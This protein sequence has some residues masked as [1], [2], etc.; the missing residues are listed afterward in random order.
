LFIEREYWIND[1]VNPIGNKKISPVVVK[2][3]ISR[4]GTIF[5]G[6]NSSAEKRNQSIKTIQ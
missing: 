5:S 3:A 6:S 2:T 4:N 1:V